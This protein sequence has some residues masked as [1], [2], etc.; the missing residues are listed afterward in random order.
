MRHFFFDARI[1]ILAHLFGM[2]ACLLLAH[3]PALTWP[4]L[5]AIGM[6]SFH[7]AHYQHIESEMNMY[8]SVCINI[9]FLIF[10]LPVLVS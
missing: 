7:Q 5:V 9:D 2:R 1:R 4:S 6:F 8:N 3:F 10:V